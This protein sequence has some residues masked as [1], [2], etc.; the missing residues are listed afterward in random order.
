MSIIKINQSVGTLPSVLCPSQFI[1]FHSSLQ[2]S[3][4]W[5][6]LYSGQSGLYTPDSPQDRKDCLKERRAAPEQWVGNITLTFYITKM[7]GTTTRTRMSRREMFSRVTIGFDL[8]IFSH[9]NISLTGSQ[10]GIPKCQGMNQ[11]ISNRNYISVFSASSQFRITPRANPFWQWVKIC[12]IIYE[13]L[14]WKTFLNK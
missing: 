6:S 14:Y 3:L 4:T 10:G 7:T 12:C 5:S 11:S 9:W 8:M 13:I 1:K 2:T